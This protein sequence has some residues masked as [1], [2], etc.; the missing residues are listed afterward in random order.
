MGFEWDLTMIYDFSN[1]F[2][3]E[4]TVKDLGVWLKDERWLMVG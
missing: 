2:L 3:S 4:F 1:T